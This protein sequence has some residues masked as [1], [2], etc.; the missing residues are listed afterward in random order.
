MG[1]EDE[2]ADMEAVEV[3][4]ME[5]DAED[6]AA[7]VDSV[8]AV[9]EVAVDMEVAVTDM[10]EMVV[11]AVADMVVDRVDMVVAVQA[12]A[13]KEVM[14]EVKEDMEAEDTKLYLIMYKIP[15]LS[16]LMFELLA[17]V[18]ISSFVKTWLVTDLINY[19][20]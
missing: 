9:D 19:L 16:I 8:V 18:V 14:V 7:V 3:A 2:E 11:M 12:T 15:F 20:I 5:G 17:S 6:M 10:V 4:D 1:V 13:V